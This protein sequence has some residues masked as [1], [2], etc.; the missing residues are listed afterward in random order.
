MKKINLL[1]FVM[2]IISALMIVTTGCK[3]D[4]N[5]SP[6]V[7]KYKVLTEYMKANNLDLN[8]MSDAWVVDAAT[9]NTNGISNYYIIDIR[10][11]ADFALGHIN[12]AVNTTLS[13]ILT[14]AANNGGKT[15]L[16]VC[17]TGQ[18]AAYGLV[19]LRLS[20]F[21]NSK[22]LKW[23]MSSWN[24]VFD[25]WT[26]NVSNQAIGHTNWST[27]NTIKTPVT[28]STP[29]ITAN[30]S[31]GPEILAERVNAMLA[32]GMQGVNAIDVLTTPSN[33]FINNYWAETDVNTYGHI[34]TA[35]RL[36]ESLT[37]AND[38]FKN[39]D[40][41]ATIVTYC[42]TGQTSA[43]ISAYLTVLGYNAKTLKFGANNMI[44]SQ[45]QANKWTSS[46][47]YPYVTS[48]K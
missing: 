13:N 5:P 42:W 8:N 47:S 21:P 24:T 12:G 23:G 35:Y 43:L 25:K 1:K 17:Y 27:T 33:Y 22:I 36:K 34:K 48:K 40:K 4:E 37:L 32:A 41:D 15:I 46:G 16:V 2:I 7:D 39:L 20:G 14:Q 11:A 38:G 9:V 31:T 29:T 18:T 26:A 3:K 6:T 44:H 45:L 10:S 30:A 28:F 19:A